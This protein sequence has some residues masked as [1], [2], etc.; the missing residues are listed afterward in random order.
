MTSFG[1]E[2]YEFYYMYR[3]METTLQSGYRMILSPQN[4]SSTT[5]L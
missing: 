3:I 5:T 4:F 1:V 2:F